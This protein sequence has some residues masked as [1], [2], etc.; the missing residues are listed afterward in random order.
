MAATPIRGTRWLKNIS[1]RQDVFGIT[2]SMYDNPYLP[3]EEI[4]KFE[5]NCESDDER[6]VRVHGKYIVFGGKPVF[7]TRILTNMLE[8]AREGEPFVFEAA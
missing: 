7:N 3:I 5:A 4:R 6:D 1:E 8:D 2:A